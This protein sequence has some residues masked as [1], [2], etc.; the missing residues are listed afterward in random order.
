M[1]GA[2]VGSVLAAAALAGCSSG[3][4]T[5]IYAYVSP[6]RSAVVEVEPEGAAEAA[7]GLRNTVYFRASGGAGQLAPLGKTARVTLGSFTGEWNPAAFAWLDGTTV[8]ACPL[9][10]DKD[11]DITIPVSTPTSRRTFRVTTEGCPDFLRAPPA[12]VRAGAG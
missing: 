4:D 9:K 8:S 3:R 11:V 12:A 7:P 6:D 1:R 10:G 2:W 5:H